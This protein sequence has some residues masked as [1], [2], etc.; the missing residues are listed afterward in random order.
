MPRA[1]ELAPNEP[2]PV[3]G[4]YKLLNLFGTPTGQEVFL[5]EGSPAPSA[6]RWHT[7]QLEAPMLE[8]GDMTVQRASRAIFGP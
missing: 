3:R 7:W 8:T 1:P 2:A 6:P 4:W 5:A